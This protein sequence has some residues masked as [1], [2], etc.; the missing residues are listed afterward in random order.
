MVNRAQRESVD[1]R[2][3]AFWVRVVDD[4]RR[5][6]EGLFAK[7]ADCASMPIRT[8]DVDAEPL[9]VQSNPDLGQGVAADLGS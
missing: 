5:L 4:V 3:D 8:Q 6:D 7:G 9:L 1:D 2:G